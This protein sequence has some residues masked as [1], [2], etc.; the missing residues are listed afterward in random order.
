LRILYTNQFIFNYVQEFDRAIYLDLDSELEQKYQTAIS[1]LKSVIYGICKTIE[2]EI[3]QSL[4]SETLNRLIIAPPTLE[5]FKSLLKLLT[6][7]Q[8]DDKEYQKDAKKLQTFSKKAVDEF[9][10]HYKARD[11]LDRHD[12]VYYSDWKF[13]PEDIEYGLST[14]LEEKFSFEY[15]EET[16]SQDLFPYLH[17]ELAKRGLTVLNIDTGG[18]SYLFCVVNCADVESVLELS[19]SIGLTIER[20]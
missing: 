11:I 14:I 15:P 6:R 1:Q 10:L 20:I 3:P 8:C 4:Q 7:N 13:D 5:T 19:Q 17:A 2:I 12:A 16:Y 18:D 9:E